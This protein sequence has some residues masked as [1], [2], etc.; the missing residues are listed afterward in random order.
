[1][2]ERTVAGQSAVDGAMRGAV[3][4][5][6]GRAV[7]G[8][9]V[10]ITNESTGTRVRART[11]AEGEFL[12]AQLAPGSYRVVVRA[13]GF[14][15]A[16]TAGVPVEVGG[17]AEVAERLAVGAVAEQVT[18]TAEDTPGAATSGRVISSLELGELPVDGRRWQS[19][20]ALLP[21]VSPDVESAE[22]GL[23]SFRGLA[24]TQNS[25]QIDGVSGDQ[26]YNATPAG[27]GEDTSSDADEDGETETLRSFS[28]G[29]DRGRKPGAAYTFTESAVREF[30]VTGQNGSALEGHAAGGVITTVSRSGGNALHG[31]G[32]FLLR[33]SAWAATN[34]FATVTTFRDGV[35]NTVYAKPHDLRQQFGGSVGGPVRHDRLFF[36]Y[37]FDD[38]RRGFPAISSPEDPNFYALTPTQTAL[39]GNR[40]VRASAVTAALTYLDSLTGVVARRAD[41]TVNFAKLDWTPRATQRFSVEENRA[42]SSSPAGLRTAPV[43]NRG[44]ASFGDSTI[45]VDSLVGRWAWLRSAR[46]SN[47]MRVQYGRDLHEERPEAPLA[48]EPAISPGGFAPEVDIGPL[49]LIFGTPASIAQGP[50]P[51]ERRVQVTE[52]ATLALEHHLLQIGADYSHVHDEVKLLPDAEGLFHYDSG[53]TGGHAGGLVD[54]ITDYTFGVNSYPNGGCPSITAAV[55]YSCFRSFTQS[56]GSGGTAFGTAEWAGY[57]QDDWRVRQGLTLGVGVRYEYEFL[58]LPQQPNGT[59]DALFGAVGATSV[60]PEDRNNFGPRVSAAWEPFGRRGGTV[61]V[62]YGIYYG[63]LPGATVRSALV[64]TATASSVTRIRILPTTETA[65]PQ[66]NGQG[67]GYPCAFTASPPTGV[68]ATTSAEVFD[69][70]FRLPMTQQ[71]TL[72]VEQPLGRGLTASASYLLDLNR[73][74]PNS[75]DVNIAPA[76]ETQ[77]YVLQGGTGA[78]GVRDGEGFTVPLY[79]SRVSTRFGP[80]TD[81]V[82]NANGTYNALAVEAREHTRGGLDMRMSFTWSKAID[83]GQNA[84]AV[85]PSNG[86]FDPF[87]VRYDKGLSAFNVPHRLVASGVWAPKVERGSA[88]RRGALGGWSVAP[89]VMESSG[90]PYSY[91]IFGGTRLTG[92]R[93]SI[94]GSG[95]LT[96]LPTVGRDVL[97]LPDTADVDVRLSRAMRFGEEVRLRAFAEVFNVANHV[98]VSSVSQ[99][100]FL[101]GTPVNGVT[102]LVFQDAAAV[103]AE[104]LNVQP[105]GTRTESTAASQER[106]VQVGVRVEF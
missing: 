102:P 106:Q 40:G 11:G 61:R 71:A 59:L 25:S 4:D 67:F 34:P 78:A 60:F 15:E 17:V 105:F 56:F 89:V 98:N 83:F 101:L 1:M 45:K 32:F 27:S 50:A 54:W 48:Q 68:A 79:T 6:T 63:R 91:E 76:T 7:V 22:T 26:S 5:A 43:V 46:V 90:R 64:N 42:R 47:E 28:A 57:A 53:V 14:A 73:Q 35:V 70:R 9:A 84:G 82:S 72:A 49:G 12:A 99:R 100:A 3:A 18:V 96:Y 95:G 38:Q 85:P 94:N 92:G 30:R 52:T 23:V 55:H 16:V 29:A 81:I 41:Q 62:A 13:M 104:G 97:R 103:A 19:L 36:F 33:E 31:T 88:L 75:V 2:A 65:C 20:A 58:P 74:L 87:D 86:Q 66:V 80:V 44:R 37:A 77:S 93:E 24:P 10:E 8:G 21:Q 51:D 69:R 39:L